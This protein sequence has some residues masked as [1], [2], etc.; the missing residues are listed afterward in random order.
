MTRAQLLRLGLTDEAIGHRTRTGRLHRIHPGVYAVGRPPK[1]A[2]E[3]ASAALLACGPAAALSH[4]SAMAL[5]G[6]W[7]QWPRPLEV[8]IVTGDRRPKGIRVHHSGGLSRRDL[9]KRHGL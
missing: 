3:L 6:F 8:T 1:T 4:S 9:R 7:K 2:L 5:W